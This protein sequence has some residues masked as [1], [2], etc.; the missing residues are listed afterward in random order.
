MSGAVT[1]T[2]TGVRETALLTLYGKAIDA[3]S[4]H[5]VLGDPTT[6]ALIDLIDYDFGRLKIPP[7]EPVK[8]AMRAKQLD[9]WIRRF[10]DTRR[11]AVVIDLG[12][13][14]DPRFHRVSFTEGVDWYDVDYPDVIKMR[15]SLLPSH[16]SRSIGADVTKLDWVEQLP[17]DK[18][19]IVV[20][21]GVLPFLAQDDA[22]AVMDRIVNHF[23]GGEIAFNGYT[24][25]AVKLMRFHPMMKALGVEGA[26]NGFTDPHTPESWV[27]RLRLA[28]EAFLVDN[29]G[30]ATM[31]ASVRLS[32]KVFSLVPALARQGGSLLRYQF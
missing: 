12:C 27:P 16:R 3:R 22:I 11:H 1:A 30:I 24:R 29:P 13:G 31:S 4:T 5:P 2:F 17:S 15:E 14:L 26:G 20:A 18:E 8:M 19:A 28:E 23:P 21:D 25:L 7:A 6:L 9:D 10:L 32:S